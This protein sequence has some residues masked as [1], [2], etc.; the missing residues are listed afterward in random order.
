MLSVNVVVIRKIVKEINMN[1]L[2][3]KISINNINKVNL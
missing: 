2:S 1:R 3:K